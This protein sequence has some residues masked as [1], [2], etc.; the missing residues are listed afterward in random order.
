MRK[1]E[2]RLT[3]LENRAG[4]TDEF[5]TSCIIPVGATPA[6]IDRITEEAIEAART[7]ADGRAISIIRRVIVA[8]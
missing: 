6:D 7:E 2:A 1:F 5:W 4:A 3:K 8:P